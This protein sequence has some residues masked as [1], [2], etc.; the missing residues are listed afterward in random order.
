MLKRYNVGPSPF[1][2]PRHS[3]SL[4]HHNGRKYDL[5]EELVS[6][7]PGSLV[8]KIVTEVLGK[9]TVD[10]HFEADDDQ[11]WSVIKIHVCEEDKE[12]NSE[13]PCKR[14]NL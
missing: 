13:R 1:C 12:M 5:Y 4:R 3:L 10:I 2:H 8:E 11:E 9:D 14:G 6:K 7:H